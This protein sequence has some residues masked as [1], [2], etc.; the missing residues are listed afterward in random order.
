LTLPAGS[1]LNKRILLGNIAALYGFYMLG[2]SRRINDE[3]R[4]LIDNQFELERVNRID[5]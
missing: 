2:L 4:L 3:Y 1:T 5:P